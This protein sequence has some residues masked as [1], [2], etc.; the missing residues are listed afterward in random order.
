M[1]FG[2]SIS[3][4]A[5][6]VKLAWHTVQNTRNA[7]SEHDELSCAALGL[8]KTLRRLESEVKNPTSLLNKPEDPYRQE[9]QILGN[10]C[11]KVLEALN[12][13]LKKYSS[14][15][16][17][18]GG[19]PKAWQR[20][21]FGNEEMTVKD[22]RAKMTFYTS[23]LSLYLNMVSMGSSGRVER[24][25]DAAGGDL[26]EIKTAVNTIT[27]HLMSSAKEEGSHMTAYAD[28]DR[29]IWREFRREL[30]KKG[31]RSSLLHKHKAT[32]QSYVNELGRRGLM[33]ESEPIQVQCPALHAVSEEEAEEQSSLEEAIKISP[34]HITISKRNVVESKLMILKTDV[35][36]LLAQLQQAIYM[37]RTSFLRQKNR[38]LMKQ[39]EVFKKN[40]H[41]RIQQLCGANF[42]IRQGQNQ[43]AMTG[44]WIWR[45]DRPHGAFGAVQPR[46]FP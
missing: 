37:K 10:G 28:D 23:A 6:L 46:M 3:D 22:I 41:F 25:M 36:S 27:A 39:Q 40:P 26:K 7:D 32:I 20:F 30:V 17:G 15:N 34:P 21:R 12:K 13:I 42:P 14:L 44:N 35:A 8:H 33:D 43:R 4:V 5:M 45:L 24:Q 29:A 2:V 19:I 31:F 16:G 11:Q 38:Q 9:I 18:S 1:S